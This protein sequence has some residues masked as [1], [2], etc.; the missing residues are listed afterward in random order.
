ME[1]E[2]NSTFSKYS[3]THKINYFRHVEKHKWD[4]QSVEQKS[5][6]MA[7]IFIWFISFSGQ[8]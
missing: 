2:K 5:C 7:C 1:G 8:Q 3:V 6:V 4:A